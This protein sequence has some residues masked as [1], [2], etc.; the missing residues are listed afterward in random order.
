M[1]IDEN[2]LLSNHLFN[3]SK[4]PD[5][6]PVPVDYDS[7]EFKAFCQECREVFLR[8]EL[9][10]VKRMFDTVKC[11]FVCRKRIAE[12]RRQMNQYLEGR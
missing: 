8:T 10:D 4:R 6:T 9:E 1:F 11:C 2:T 12:G 5:I 3:A 7:L